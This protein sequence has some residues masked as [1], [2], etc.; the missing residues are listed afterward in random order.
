MALREYAGRVPL[1]EL[2]YFD[3]NYRI[4]WRFM[5][6]LTKSSHVLYI[7]YDW[8]VQLEQL[9]RQVG[10]LTVGT[11]NET[12]ITF[13]HLFQDQCGLKNISFLKLDDL[14][15]FK[16][17]R[18]K[19]D[20]LILDGYSSWVD[21]LDRHKMWLHFQGLLKEGGCLLC[22]TE[23]V[24]WVHKMAFLG[25]LKRSLLKDMPPALWISSKRKFLSSISRMSREYISRW[26]FEGTRVYLLLPHYR[27][28]KV[29]VPLDSQGVFSYFVK[30]WALARKHSIRNPIIRGLL[31]FIGP[32]WRLVYWSLDHLSPFASIVAWK[33]KS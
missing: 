28:S 20:I 31:S 11:S 33:E 32:L 24:N 25:A 30:S 9:A 15:S 23:V 22:N 12:K 7:G 29:I 18:S 21:N 13:L 17:K 5:L 1:S 3:D 27:D 26:G 4:I 19:Y 16:E 6:P 2:I 14:N 10:S 8:G